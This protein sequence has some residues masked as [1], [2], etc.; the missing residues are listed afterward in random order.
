MD[1]YLYHKYDVSISDMSIHLLLN[2]DAS[3]GV[4]H[5]C[6]RL[7]LAAPICTSGEASIPRG[8]ASWRL[9]VSIDMN[10]G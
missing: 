4:L 3:V 10:L 8:S 2:L 7:V 1:V 6:K 5:R 9:L